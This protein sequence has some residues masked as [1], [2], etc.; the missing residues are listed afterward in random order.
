[1]RPKQTHT[2]RSRPASTYTLTRRHHVH[3][4]RGYR[5]LRHAGLRERKE[6]RKR[7]EGSISHTNRAEWSI[8][9]VERVRGSAPFMVSYLHLCTIDLEARSRRRWP[10]QQICP[11]DVLKTPCFRE[12]KNLAKAPPARKVSVKNQSELTQPT[13]SSTIR[14]RCELILYA[15]QQSPCFSIFSRERRDFAD[16]SQFQQN[17]C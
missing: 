7:D 15:F 2:R 12:N 1:M 9:P 4:H 14:Q 11:F 6:R 8:G 17:H 16:F 10:L 13:E 5:L 3:V